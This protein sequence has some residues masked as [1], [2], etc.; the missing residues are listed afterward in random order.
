M[1]QKPSP[2]LLHSQTKIINPGPYI[3]P[4]LQIPPLPLHRAQL[5]YEQFSQVSQRKHIHRLSVIHSLVHM[6]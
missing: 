6:V 5:S 1:P 3:Y 2:T 4:F